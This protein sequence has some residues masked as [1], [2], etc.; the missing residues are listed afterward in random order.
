MITPGSTIKWPQMLR[1]RCGTD[2]TT[3]KE[4]VDWNLLFNESIPDI[5]DDDICDAIT[6][7]TGPEGNFK[8][9]RRVTQ[10]DVEIWIFSMWKSKKKE[11][12]EDCCEYCGIFNPLTGQREESTGWVGADWIVHS[13]CWIIAEEPSG[14]TRRSAVPCMCTRGL[15]IDRKIVEKQKFPNEVDKLTW[16]RNH[17]TWLESCHDQIRG[18]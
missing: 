14:E 2:L 15:E 16:K 9:N 7:A 13:G 18:R 4:Y 17:Q 1:A 3:K 5:Q 8:I 12:H 10:R 11:G 6:W